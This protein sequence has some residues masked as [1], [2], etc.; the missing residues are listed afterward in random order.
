MHT[1][2]YC[3]VI[4]LHTTK[5]REYNLASSLWM[6]NFDNQ[7]YQDADI[8]PGEAMGTHSEIG[9]MTTTHLLQPC[10]FLSV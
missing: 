3:S 10:A 6:K 4:I 1:V 2:V 7:L 9:L 8:N 5:K